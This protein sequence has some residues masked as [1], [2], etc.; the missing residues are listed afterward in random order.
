MLESKSFLKENTFDHLLN[1]V[2]IIKQPLV[3]VQK[4]LPIQPTD[5]ARTIIVV[6]NGALLGLTEQEGE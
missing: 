4:K 5:A 3:S 6:P 1:S 2:A